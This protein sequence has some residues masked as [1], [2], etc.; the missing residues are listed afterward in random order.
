MM[1]DILELTLCNISCFTP[2]VSMIKNTVF[3]IKG[4]LLDL[5]VY[6]NDLLNMEKKALV[7]GIEIL[8]VY[9]DIF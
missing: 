2:V 4:D 8:N 7:L 9:I 6:L 1:Y 3:L 5:R